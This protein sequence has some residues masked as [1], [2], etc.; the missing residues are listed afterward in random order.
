MRTAFVSIL[1][2]F[3]AQTHAQA[4]S[5]RDELMSRLGLSQ[6]PHAIKTT[7]SDR[8]AN[9]LVPGN[10]LR[11]GNMAPAQVMEEK[12]LE[13]EN[14]LTAKVTE[15]RSEK[16]LT[17]LK[18]GKIMTKEELALKAK[19]AQKAFG[20][21]VLASLIEEEKALDGQ[22]LAQKKKALEFAEILQEQRAKSK[23]PFS[24]A[25]KKEIEE[26]IAKNAQ[27]HGLQMRE[28]LAEAMAM[29]KK[30][31][32]HPLSTAEVKIVE[33]LE[34]KV[35]KELEA[36]RVA[37]EEQI[38]A[39]KKKALELVELLEENAAKSKHPLSAAEK[40]QVQ[41]EIEK[42]SQAYAHEMADELEEEKALQKKAFGHPLS[43]IEK[44]HVEQFEAKIQNSLSNDVL[45]LGM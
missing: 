19:A 24:A 27:E 30:T 38:Q 9:K 14:A 5:H 34:M 28:Q 22:V 3:V 17:R 40:K 43:A 23:H 32:G 20:E 18:K 4:Q 41:E 8:I 1:L 31:L 29:Q 36:S 10:F 7:L 12:T 39:K 42:S 6:G 44:K 37:M 33:R 45:L 21:K 35:Q 2:R 11:K 26:Q 25:E 15:Q 13:R 16:L